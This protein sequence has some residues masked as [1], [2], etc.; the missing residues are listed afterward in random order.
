MESTVASDRSQELT[1]L[2]GTVRALLKHSE[3]EEC[4]ILITDA[5]GK[6]PH[7]PEP[8]NLFGVLLERQCDH[9]AAMKHFRAA[10][11]L[12]PTYVPARCNLN[13]YGSFYFKGQCAIDETDCNV[14]RADGVKVQYD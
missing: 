7:A 1:L 10:C 4:T 9:L 14:T 6:H 12:D 3:F 2:C 5:M 11:A 8:H 13:N